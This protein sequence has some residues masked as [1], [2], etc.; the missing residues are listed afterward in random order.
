MALIHVDQMRA[1][2]LMDVVLACLQGWQRAI[3]EHV[4]VPNNVRA[5]NAG[6]MVVRV[7]AELVRLAKN[8]MEAHAVRLIAMVKLAGMMAAAIPMA[9]VN[10]KRSYLF[11]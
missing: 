9:A 11:R 8:A 5:N 7:L 6:M 4:L 2:T 3:K 1:G 10:A